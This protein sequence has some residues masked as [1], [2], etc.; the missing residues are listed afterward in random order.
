V[1]EIFKVQESIVRK[2]YKKFQMEGRVT[3][4]KT[5]KRKSK[6]SHNTIRDKNKYR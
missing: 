6:L 1:A 2:V 4:K 3:K 5:G